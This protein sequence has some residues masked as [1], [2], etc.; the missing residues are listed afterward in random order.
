MDTPFF[1]YRRNG[2]VAW[3]ESDRWKPDL[4]HRFGHKLLFLKILSPQR[5]KDFKWIV[6]LAL[7]DGSWYWRTPY[8]LINLAW[9][10]TL[11]AALFV[12]VHTI[13]LRSSADNEQ[14]AMQR[15]SFP[16]PYSS[17]HAEWG[18]GSFRSNTGR[19]SNHWILHTQNRSKAAESGFQAETYGGR[20][21]CFSLR[22]SKERQNDRLEKTGTKVCQTGKLSKAVWTVRQF[23]IRTSLRI[24]VSVPP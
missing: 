12:R 8:G 11:T 7:T 3:K 15:L 23:K 19:R 1:E 21:S 20:P 18:L 10:L 6:K 14:H 22:T 9:P 4:D 5:R 24:M 17:N 13:T 2:V 16:S